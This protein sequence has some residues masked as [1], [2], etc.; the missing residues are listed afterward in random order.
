MKLLQERSDIYVNEFD[1]HGQTSLMRA[2]KNGHEAVVEY[3]LQHP[4]IDVNNTFRYSGG[5]SPLMLAVHYGR[6]TIV[7]DL[8]K[9]PKIDVDVA[10]FQRHC[11]FNCLTKWKEDGE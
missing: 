1:K 9:H 4:N 6:E 11:S 2:I 7:Q 3:L 8:L 5:F 10:S